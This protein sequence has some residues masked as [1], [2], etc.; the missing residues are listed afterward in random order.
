MDI[1]SQKI[2]KKI[3]LFF[4]FVETSQTW[5]LVQRM[6]NQALFKNPDYSDPAGQ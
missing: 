3:S 2:Y 6:Q 4:I 5:I 1:V